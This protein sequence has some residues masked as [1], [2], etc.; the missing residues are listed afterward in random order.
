MKR[1]LRLPE[2]GNFCHHQAISYIYE[3]ELFPAL[4]LTTFD[5]LCVNVFMS[6][7]CVILGL[8]HLNYVKHVNRVKNLIN[9][10]ECHASQPKHAKEAIIRKD[11]FTTIRCYTA[12]AQG[13][14]KAV[15][16]SATT[17]TSTT[18]T[19]KE[20]EEESTWQRCEGPTSSLFEDSKMD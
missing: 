14:H 19:T 11:G 9:R 1:G 6:G 10:S 15:K 18:T 2:L 5:P 7:K 8:K 20:N 17:L 3:P 16:S 12:E 13:I 4:R